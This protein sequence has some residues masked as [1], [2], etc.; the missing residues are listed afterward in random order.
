M[1]VA[2]QSMK[3]VAF[4]QRSEIKADYLYTASCNIGSEGAGFVPA[5]IKLSTYND[6]EHGLG[7]AL[8]AGGITI[9]EPSPAGDLLVGEEN[10]RD[11]AVGQEV[12]IFLGQS[13]QVHVQCTGRDNV[14]R[15][16]NPRKWA[17][18]QS[19]I[20]NANGR[21]VIVRLDIGRSAEWEVRRAR[22]FKVKDG[23]NVLQLKVPVNGSTTITWQ[24][25]PA[26]A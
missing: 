8:P 18:M 22:G 9:F 21:P 7:V 6:R 19:V 3:Q 24:L 16:D 23:R 25:R 1:T 12:E 17:Q 4:L 2:A 15:T 10:I 5:G 14:Q 11:Y 20:R 26:G 13:T